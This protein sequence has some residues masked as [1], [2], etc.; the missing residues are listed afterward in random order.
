MI[1]LAVMAAA[2]LTLTAAAGVLLA[3]GIDR[4]SEYMGLTI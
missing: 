1:Y 3:A 2:I 4:A